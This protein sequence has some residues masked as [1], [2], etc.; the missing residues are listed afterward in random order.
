MRA[1]WD[2]EIAVLK[3]ISPHTRCVSLLDTVELDDCWCLV[4]EYVP[5]GE[6]FDWV[7]KEQS[8]SGTGIPESEARR[9]FG[10]ILEG[11]FTSCSF[12]ACRSYEGPCFRSGLF[13]CTQR[14]TSGPEIGKYP[15]HVASPPHIACPLT[16]RI[17]RHTSEVF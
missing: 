12:Y 16:K 6:L 17:Y 1:S 11:K 14:D 10:E 9:I 7:A 13:A 2:R 4:M 5:G 3:A 15:P 8:L